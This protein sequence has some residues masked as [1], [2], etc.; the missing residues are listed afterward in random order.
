MRAI[1]YNG[2]RAELKGNV[3]LRAPG[4][5]EVVVAIQA[6]GV[7]HSDVSVLN[8]T[9]PFPTPVVMGHEGAGVVEAVGSEVKAVAPGDHVVIATLA[10]CGACGPCSSGHPT[11]CLTTLGNVDTPFSVDGEPAYNFAACSVFAER[12]VVKEVQAV[13]IPKD[14][15]LTSACLIACGVLTGAGAV[16]NRCKVQ[17]G[18]TAAVFGVGGVG[19][20][21]IQALRISGATHIIA[22]DTVNV[23][24]QLARQFGATHFVNASGD[25][26]AERVRA[27]V[28]R[29]EEGRAAAFAPVFGVDWAYDC[30]GH[31]AVLKNAFDSLGW[32]GTAVAIGV[33]PRGSEISIDINTLAYVDRGLIGNR[34]GST[35]PHAD[36]ALMIE[37]YK[38]GQLLLDELVSV[39]RPVEEFDAIVEAMHHGKVAR[40]VITF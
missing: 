26:V 17:P 14:V 34:Y 20:N 12:T 39:L 19:L 32:G 36:I 8:G 30:V 13:K 21:V 11:W 9:I 16:L 2:E 18:D 10:S 25:D 35:R 23:K 6:A 22:V 15:P 3:D 33:P 31:K 27:L 38:S 7:C 40:G 24:E 28:P 29:Q 4:P 37:Y 5:R 1:V